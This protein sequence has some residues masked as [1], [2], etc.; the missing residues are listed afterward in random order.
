MRFEYHIYHSEKTKRERVPHPF[1][2]DDEVY[3]YRQFP[4]LFNEHYE[5]RYAGSIKASCVP[6]EPEKCGVRVTLDTELSKVEADNSLSG[7]LSDLNTQIPGL[8]LLCFSAK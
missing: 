2:E 8:N 6:A 4:T 1:S 3:E 7:L 5:R